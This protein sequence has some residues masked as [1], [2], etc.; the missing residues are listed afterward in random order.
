LLKLKSSAVS[1]LHLLLE[2]AREQLRRGKGKMIS[3]AR[4]H[5][6]NPT[7]AV[8]KLLASDCSHAYHMYY[9]DITCIC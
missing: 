2:T 5:K 1:S 7:Q 9:S 6:Y 4:R 8:I 3:R